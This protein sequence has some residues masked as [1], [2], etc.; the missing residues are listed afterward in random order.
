MTAYQ[1][2]PFSR[3][4]RVMLACAV[5][6]SLSACSFVSKSLDL[7]HFGLYKPEVVQGNFVSREQRQALRLGMAR[8]Q[9]KDILGTPLVASVFHADRWDYV[10][11]IRRQGV[12][13]QNFKLSVHF[14]ADV[15]AQIDS[16][17]LPSE[18]EFVQRL[19]GEKKTAPPPLLQASEEELRKFPPAKSAPSA[20]AAPLPPLPAS[21]P[22]LE[23]GAR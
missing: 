14:K 1:S 17:E 16:D 18:N 5:A 13:P 12:A 6:V 9:V 7:E 11:T 2:F 10:F 4:L 3:W 15:L 22:P 23:P 8:A 21:Y 20:P 19:V